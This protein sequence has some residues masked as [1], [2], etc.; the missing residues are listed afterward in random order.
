MTVDSDGL[1]EIAGDCVTLVAGTF[2]R[3]LDWQLDSLRELDDVCRLL[4]AAGQLPADRLDLWWKV[5][6]AY[7]GEVMI[8]AHDGR[9]I[10]HELAAGAYAIEID[11]VIGF[12]FATAQRVLD[13]E[14]FKSLAAFGRTFEGLRDRPGGP[15]SP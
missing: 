10:E 9:W 12:P 7:V 14:P 1:R 11:G 5:I 2:G 15:V 13:G 6:G 8:G 3:T 4:L